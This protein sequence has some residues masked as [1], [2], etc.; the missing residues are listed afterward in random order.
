MLQHH[1][2]APVM[3]HKNTCLLFLV[4]LLMT[5]CGTKSLPPFYGHVR[6][7]HDGDT[8]SVLRRSDDTSNEA[9][10]IRV[11]LARIDAPELSQEFGIESRDHLLR[12]CNKQEIRVIP[13]GWDR[14]HRLIADIQ[15]NGKCINYEQVESGFAWWYQ[16][17][18]SVNPMMWSAQ[19]TAQIRRVGLWQSRKPTAPWDYRR[20]TRTDRTAGDKAPIEVVTGGVLAALA[21]LVSMILFAQR[22]AA[23]RMPKMPNLKDLSRSEVDRQIDR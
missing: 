18:D 14:N 1:K 21:G 7:V 9:E 12:A 15:L 11:R 16:E 13:L 3:H 6:N 8:I 20:Q 17:Y 23:L 10:V 19:T 2:A 22:I 4:P 5:G